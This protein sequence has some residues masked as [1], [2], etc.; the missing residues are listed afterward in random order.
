[1]SIRLTALLLLVG[2]SAAVPA[3]EQIYSTGF[4]NAEGFQAS[5]DPRFTSVD[6]WQVVSGEA[7][8]STAV[9]RV[10]TQ[11][12]ELTPNTVLDRSFESVAQLTGKRI[13]WVRGWFRG[14]GSATAPDFSSLGSAS[15]IVYFGNTGIQAF[16]GNNPPNGAGSFVATG[17]SLSASA[18]NEVVLMLDFQTKTYDVYVRGEAEALTTARRTNT[19]LRF[20]NDV[21]RLNGFQNLASETSFIDEF[22][23]LTRLALDANGDG[24]VNVADAVTIVNELGAPNTIITDPILRVNADGDLNGTIA[25]ADLSSLVNGLLAN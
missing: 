9:F 16:N 19:G 17:R 24:T 14:A 15:A 21:A 10:G 6:G 12:V 11:S 7:R 23:V 5:P 2:L 18:W 13:V 20:R 25:Q 1:M 22:K 4:E 8:V 3:F